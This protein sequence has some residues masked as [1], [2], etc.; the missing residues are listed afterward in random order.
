MSDTPWMKFYPRDWRGD[1]S[2]R[3][4]SLAARGLWM[5]CLCLMHEAK[6]YGHLLLAGQPVG[7]D[8]LSRMVGSSL[9]EIGLLL[10]ELEKAGVF[11]RT[12]NDVIY[13]RRM[14]KDFQA[15]RTGKKAVEKR[16]A[17]TRNPTASEVIETTEEKSDPN[18]VPNRSPIRV[19]ITQ[20]PEGRSQKEAAATRA[21]PPPTAT[22]PP[23]EAAAAATSI[24]LQDKRDRGRRSAVTDEAVNLHRWICE[25][26]GVPNGYRKDLGT[27][28][29]WLEAGHDAERH[30]K[31]GI[32]DV[33]ARNGGQP[34][35]SL[36]YFEGAIADR[37]RGHPVP[38]GH[39]PKTPAPSRR[40][41]W[42]TAT[43][44]DWRQ[45]LGLWARQAARHGIDQARWPEFARW[46]PA[47]PMGPPPDHPD[48][49]AP[50][51]MVDEAMREA[52]LELSSVAVSQ[53]KAAGRI[54]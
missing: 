45:R 26:L 28:V 36:R 11:S 30:I 44:A 2:L 14:T 33:M 20:K 52:G 10:A 9:D 46:R 34:F 8:V 41:D 1:Q 49:R 25:R 5:E 16:W 7:N 18:R 51:A 40:I 17:K 4:V 12:A 42:Q 3:A 35:M 47:D 54:K 13:S 48:C 15:S 21:D 43:E 53:I 6:P 24:D 50:P 19:P 31:A 38:S 23:P 37:R 22:D 27:V 39:P 32:D 29:G